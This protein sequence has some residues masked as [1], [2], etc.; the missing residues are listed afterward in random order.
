[1]LTDLP[2]GKAGNKFSKYLI[3]A[4]GEIVLVIIGILIALQIN[5]WNINQSNINESSEFVNRLKAEITSNIGFTNEEIKRKENQKRSS[6]AILKMFNKDITKLSSRTFDS[7][8]NICMAN[9]NMEFK[10]GTLSEGLN[11]GKVALI[12]SDSLKSLL[13]G[14][15]SLVEEVR[16]GEKYFNDDLN[17][18]FYPFIYEHISFRQMDAVHSNYAE[19]IGPSKFSNHNNL[20]VLNILKFESLIDNI[21]Y[22]SNIQ[23]D[24]YLKL[25]NELENLYELIQ[26]HN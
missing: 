16:I 10:N 19:Q 6:L 15:P 25:K 2:D 18:Y 14:L 24:N 5:N 26:E 4:I 8:V 20:N 17:E 23:I 3:Y 13:Y 7:L 1:M 9:G 12:K 11:T 22:N 21:F